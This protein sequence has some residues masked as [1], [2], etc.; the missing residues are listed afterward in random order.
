MGLRRVNGFFKRRLR[1]FSLSTTCGAKRRVSLK[2]IQP[3][4][5]GPSTTN[6]P[7]SYSLVKVMISFQREPRR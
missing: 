1:R 7:R 6:T 4:A 2:M 5:A 3:R